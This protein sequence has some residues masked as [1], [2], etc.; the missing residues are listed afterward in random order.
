MTEVINSPEEE[1]RKETWLKTLAE[2]I[3]IANGKTWAA[4][5]PKIDPQ[6]PGFKELQWP[7]P[8]NMSEKD[9]EDYKGWEDW[10]LRDSYAGYFRAPGMTTVYYKGKPA[11]YMHYGGHGLT[12][13]N[14]AR[15]K[16]I[17]QF[18]KSSLMRVRA[19]MPFRGPSFYEEGGLRYTFKHKGD[20]EDCSW[21]ER[22]TENGN[23]FFAQ[24][25]TAGTII[26]KDQNRQP[27][28]P[29]NL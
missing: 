14:E 3:V 18:L 6:R 9:L 26:D 15:V 23:T 5:A 13:G 16:E 11:W 20:V 12:E 28:A 27:I 29:W 17:F 19:E 25:G 1:T 22:I 2:F 24:T 4:D 8:T 21:E 7:Y 10:L